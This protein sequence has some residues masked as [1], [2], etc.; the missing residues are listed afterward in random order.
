MLGYTG[1]DT[2]LILPTY[3][4]QNYKIYRYAFYYHDDITSVTIPNSVTS[5]GED[6]F[7]NCDSL[8]SVTIGNS[9]TSIGDDAFYDCDSLTSVE[10][11]DTE[12]WWYASN[13]TATSGTSIS[14]TE[15]ADKATAAKYLTDTYDDYY[16]KRG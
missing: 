2:A 8:T 7:Y 15:L 4:N 14:S 11:K 1:T 10:F 6:A 5:I 9:V 3:N 16:W 12:G 13:S